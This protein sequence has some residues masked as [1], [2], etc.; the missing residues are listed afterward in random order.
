[1][2]YCKSGS[3]IKEPKIIEINIVY[4]NKGFTFATGI[5]KFKNE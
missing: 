1:L 5:D 3:K 2:I 4:P